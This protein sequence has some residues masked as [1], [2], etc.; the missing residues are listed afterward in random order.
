MCIAQTTCVY[1]TT[2]QGMTRCNLRS[3]DLSLSQNLGAWCPMAQQK[4]AIHESFLRENLFFTNPRK[5]SPSKVSRYN[6]NGILLK[7]MIYN[8]YK[9][10]LCLPRTVMSVLIGSHLK[11]L[12]LSCGDEQ[13]CYSR[14][15]AA[16]YV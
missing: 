15:V 3:R 13:N 2:L 6:Y 10:T 9:S 14:W 4:R 16:E 8:L 11:N 1:R 5:F 7:V 12:C